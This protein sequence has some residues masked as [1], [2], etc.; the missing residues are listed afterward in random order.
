MSRLFRQGSI[1]D[2]GKSLSHHGYKKVI[3]VVLIVDRSP[4]ISTSNIGIGRILRVSSGPH[5]AHVLKSQYSLQHLAVRTTITH[6]G[7]ARL[8][9][10]HSVGNPFKESLQPS[11]RALG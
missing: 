4:R 1:N 3:S 5:F 8:P 11:L 10:G 6:Q 7:H 9:K 2:M